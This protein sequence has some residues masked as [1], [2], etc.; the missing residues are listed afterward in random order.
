MEDRDSD[1]MFLRL[2]DDLFWEEDEDD[3]VG[4]V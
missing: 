4:P 2:D 3:A 1:L